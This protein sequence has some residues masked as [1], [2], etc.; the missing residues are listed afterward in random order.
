M[1][2]KDS[3]WA[4]VNFFG[5]RISALGEQSRGWLGGGSMPVDISICSTSCIHLWK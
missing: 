2:L 4:R 1:E 3:M 5:S